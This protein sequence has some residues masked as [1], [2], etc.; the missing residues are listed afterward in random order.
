MVSWK[1]VSCVSLEACWARSSRKKR[2]IL[3]IGPIKFKYDRP[4]EFV[5]R[6]NNTT[7]WASSFFC[8]GEGLRTIIDSS[9]YF[10]LK[11][12]IHVI[13]GTTAK[14]PRTEILGR[15]TCK[16]QT[17]LKY[18]TKT[19]QRDP[20]RLYRSVPVTGTALRER[21]TIKG[22]TT[23]TKD[24]KKGVVYQLQRPQEI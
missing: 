19:S 15:A 24:D 20:F 7:G 9:D 2:V 11:H 10:V 17:C 12:Y 1:E 5:S 22:K 16:F 18:Y 21:N 6:C 8:D 4:N 14:T 23:S 3:S 13:T